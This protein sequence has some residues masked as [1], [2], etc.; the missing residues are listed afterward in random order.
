V[1]R[2]FRASIY[3]P[4][5]VRLF[6][7]SDPIHDD[8]SVT[9]AGEKESLQHFLRI[10]HAYNAEPK[11]LTQYRRRAYISSAD[12]YA[13]ITFDLDFRYTPEPAFN[14]MPDEKRMIPYDNMETFFPDVECSV[15]LE[16]KCYATQVPLWMLDMIRCFNLTRR[17]FSKYTNATM[18]LL[19]RQQ[20]DP[21]ILKTA[22]LW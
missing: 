20:Y 6:D 10:V 16:L 3:T 21:D 7:P 8:P 1:V 9:S 17:S 18:K 13:R 5:W 2:K 12:E 15:I 22:V 11:I 14:I 19:T 4:E